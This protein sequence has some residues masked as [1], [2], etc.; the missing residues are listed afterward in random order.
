VDV[1]MQPRPMMVL[2]GERQRGQQVSPIS[3]QNVVGGR[4]K[5]R[6]CHSALEAED[7]CDVT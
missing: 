5:C 3:E 1:W 2:A 4:P 7:G 6:I